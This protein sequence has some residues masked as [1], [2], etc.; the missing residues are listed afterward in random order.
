[1]ND[2]DVVGLKR[3]MYEELEEL[4]KQLEDHIDPTSVLDVINNVSQYYISHDLQWG[5]ENN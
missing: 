4:A 3:E 1:M 5:F 2:V